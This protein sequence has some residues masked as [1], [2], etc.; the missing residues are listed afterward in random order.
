LRLAR[1]FGAKM[2]RRRL[3][4]EL[5]QERLAEA[6]GLDRSYVS[7][8]ERGEHLPSLNVIVKLAHA[9]GVPPADLIP[10]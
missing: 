10:G 9:L 6:A 7:A 8:I 2:K 3:E 1:E 4:L 5:S